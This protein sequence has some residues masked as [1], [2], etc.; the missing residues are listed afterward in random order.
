M[1]PAQDWR[2]DDSM[3][4]GQFVTVR[5]DNSNRRRIRKPGPQAAMWPTAV[6]M[7]H[8]SAHDLAQ[9]RF[10]E[11]NEEVQTLAANGTHEALA[12]GV[13][14]RRL[15]RRS[16]DRQTH[17]PQRAIHPLRVNAVAIVDH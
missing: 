1:E 3:P 11:R 15:N 16:E 7:R 2:Y 8:P 12:K 6:V 13:R 14:L 9:M 5:L 10:G 4:I 17:R